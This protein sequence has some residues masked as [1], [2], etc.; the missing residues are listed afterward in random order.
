MMK[1]NIS[2]PSD[3]PFKFLYSNPVFEKI[4]LPSND[5]FFVEIKN[6]MFRTALLADSLYKKGKEV[7]PKTP[8]VEN[9]AIALLFECF[10][11]MMRTIY[12][13][14]TD[15]LKKNL[16]KKESL[17]NSFNKFI[18]NIRNDKYPSI[19]GKLRKCLIEDHLDFRNFKNL[20]DSIKQKTA[21]VDV[22]SKKNMY[23]V[24]ATYYDSNQDNKNKIDEALSLLI[25]KYT[26]SILVL[27]LLIDEQIK[28]KK[29][30]IATDR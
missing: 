3:I 4:L 27:T 10:I 18:K 1:I 23:Y 16:S 29:Q 2:G 17:P 6:R 28:N 26:K 8:C 24:R 25:Y 15:V 13:Y 22:Y 7:A 9:E 11:F 12:D 30:L 5:P 21:N 19:D 20:R 14:L